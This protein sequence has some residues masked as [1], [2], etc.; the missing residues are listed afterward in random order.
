LFRVG[1]AAYTVR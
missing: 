1:G